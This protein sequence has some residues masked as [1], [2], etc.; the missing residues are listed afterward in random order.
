[1]PYGFLMVFR[2]SKFITEPQYGTPQH[3]PTQP[4]TTH[5]NATYH[6]TTHHNTT[7]HNTTQLLTVSVEQNASWGFAT[8]VSKAGVLEFTRGAF[9]KDADPEIVTTR[10]AAHKLWRQPLAVDLEGSP[11]VALNEWHGLL[12]R[13]DHR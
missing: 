11:N 3:S 6:N 13:A 10:S 5:H 8:F 1:M 2:W 4:N 7:Q 12:R 9:C